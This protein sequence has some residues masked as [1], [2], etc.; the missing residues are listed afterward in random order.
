MILNTHASPGVYISVL[1]AVE[2]GLNDQ[3]ID[4]EIDRK[5]L[6]GRYIDQQTYINS[7]DN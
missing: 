5:K 2:V 6:R 1:M 7:I 4:R 3:E